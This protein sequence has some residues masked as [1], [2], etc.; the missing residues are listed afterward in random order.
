MGSRADSKEIASLLTKLEYK[1]L[2]SVKVSPKTERKICRQ[3]GIN[4]SVVSPTI[5]NLMLRGYIESTTKRHVL[6]LSTEYFSITVEGLAAFEAN[7]SLFNPFSRV[8]FHLKDVLN[9]MIS[10]NGDG[11]WYVSVGLTAAKIT[12]GVIKSMIVK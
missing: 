3:V 5:T 12:Y 7:V 11:S 10:K 9:A 2:E 6:F 8:I 4:T 1:I